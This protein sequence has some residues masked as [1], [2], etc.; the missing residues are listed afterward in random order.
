MHEPVE[1]PTTPKLAAKPMV[2]LSLGALA[3]LVLS[4][5]LTPQSL[6]GISTCVFYAWT[7][8]PCA[9]CGMTRAFCSLGHGSWSAAWAYHPLS[10]PLYAFT[11]VVAAWPVLVRL[12]PG[13]ARFATPRWIGGFAI[14]Y[15]VAL[16][17]FGVARAWSLIAPRL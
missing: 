1:V 7:G 14:A 10:F 2:W 13:V 4:F 11:I 3:V 6:P 5:W 8:V 16:A 15:A 17:A 9:G 12:I